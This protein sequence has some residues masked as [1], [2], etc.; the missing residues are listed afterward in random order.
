MAF[1]KLSLSYQ[2]SVLSDSI[3]LRVS[4][5]GQISKPTSHANQS[6]SP[7]HSTTEGFK[8]LNIPTQRETHVLLRKYLRD[9]TYTFHVIHGPTL[10]DMV[11]RLYL[12]LNQRGQIQPGPATLLL[13]IIASVTHQWTRNDVIEYGLFSSPEA[14]GEQNPAWVK[15]S[16]D[17]ADSS[18]R[19]GSLSLEHVQGLIIASSVV[20]G[21]EGFSQRYRSIFS[22]A[23]MIAQEI[24]LHSVDRPINEAVPGSDT[25]SGV[26]AEMRRRV[27][28][29][30]TGSD[31]S[32]HA[33]VLNV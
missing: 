19:S 27:W 14:A 18:R 22:T 15:A 12:Q 28:W 17:L 5:L 1:T 26:E 24:G 30:L 7:L 8:R 9:I 33:G 23:V 32:V 25:L 10:T 13:S 21:I 16:L 3:A 20:C 6:Y 11:D 2:G 4:S 31:W 29:F